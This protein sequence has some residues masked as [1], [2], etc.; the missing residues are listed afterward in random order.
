MDLDPWSVMS[1]VEVVEAV[2][3]ARAME[4]LLHN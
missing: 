1:A 3:P 2:E 4:T